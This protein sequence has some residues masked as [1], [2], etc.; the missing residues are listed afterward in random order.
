MTRID[1]RSTMLTESEIWLT[2]QASPFVRARTDTGSSPTGTDPR[3]T[4][5]PPETSYTSSRASAVFTASS[6]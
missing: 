6:S 3:R 4:G 1:D 2:T 5:T